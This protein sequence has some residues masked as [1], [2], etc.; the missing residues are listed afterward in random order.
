MA[1]TTHTVIQIFVPTDMVDSATQMFHLNGWR[2]DD[3]CDV[4]RVGN[5]ACRTL[6]LWLPPDEE[7]Q[8]RELHEHVGR[9]LDEYA[10]EPRCFNGNHPRGVDGIC[11]LDGG[12]S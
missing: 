9:F 5:V 6:A 7:I 11:L 2:V 4:T 8:T 12:R 1:Q 3:T 10:E